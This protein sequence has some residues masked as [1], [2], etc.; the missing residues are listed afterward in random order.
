[1][2]SAGECGKSLCTVASMGRGSAAPGAVPYGL[3]DVAAQLV[4]DCPMACG[5]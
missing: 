3:W 1:M 4:G 2:R 5:M